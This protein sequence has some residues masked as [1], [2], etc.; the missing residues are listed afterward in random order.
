MSWVN[1]CYK[2]GWLLRVTPAPPPD[3]INCGKQKF[4][5]WMVIGNT[6][7]EKKLYPLWL[8]YCLVWNCRV[9]TLGK[10]ALFLTTHLIYNQA[11]SS[12]LKLHK[13]FSKS[14]LEHQ[15]LYKEIRQNTQLPMCLKIPLCHW[16]SRWLCS[17]VLPIHCSQL[18]SEHIC[19]RSLLT[20]TQEEED[21]A[22]PLQILFYVFW[23]HRWSQILA[24]GI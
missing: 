5:E 7:G 20:L 18:P 2:R 4:D 24:E 23:C 22:C 21:L 14:A 9:G 16:V 17:S 3:M 1:C 13:P 19:I 8:L 12:L 15:R 10:H 6:E 11:A